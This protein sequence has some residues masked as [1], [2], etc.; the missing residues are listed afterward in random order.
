MK[1][2]SALLLTTSVMGLILGTFIGQQGAQPVHAQSQPAAPAPFAA[3]PMP[4]PLAVDPVVVS[5]TGNGAFMVTQND[6]PVPASPAPPV[7]TTLATQPATPVLTAQANTPQSAPAGEPDETALRYFAQQGDTVRLQREIERLRAL[8][9]NWQPPADPLATDFEPDQDIIAIWDMVTAGDYSGARAAIASKQEADP[10]FVPTADLLETIS[11]G[12][13]GTRLRTA[14]DSGDYQAVISLAANAPQLL[15]CASVDNLWR[16]GEAFIRTGNTQRGIDAYVY[17][18]TNCTDTA[19][20][21]ATLQKALELLDRE[22]IEPL[23]ALE[24]PAADGTGEFAA[25]K[26]DLAR[27]SIAAALEDGGEAPSEEDVTLLAAAARQSENADD[28]R[29]LG[30][31]ELDRDKPQEARRYFESAFD[32]DRS[33]QSA[34][35]LGVS[36]L[37]L[38]D[39]TAAEDALAP[40]LGESDTIDQVYGDAAAAML[41]LEPRRAVSASVLSRVVAAANESRDASIAQELGWYA[42]AYNQP[43]TAVEWFETALAWQSDLEPAAYGLM[44]AANVL[45]DSTRVEE[46]RRL[47]G[48][49]SVRIAQFGATTTSGTAIPPIPKPRPAHLAQAPVQ[50]VR[51]TTVAPQVAQVSSGG[52]ASAAGAS[53][54]G[55][56]GGGS[57][58][59]QAYRPPMSLSPAG[60]LSHAWCLMELNRPAQAADHFSRALDS[61]TQSV[62]SDAAYGQSLAFLRMGLAD[63]AAVA[64]AAAP[65]T[66]RRAVELEIAIL[67]DKATSAY[68][69]GEYAMTLNLLDARARFAPERNDLLTLRGWSYFHLKRY[70]E[71]ERIFEAV[72]ATGYGDAVAGL[73]ASRASLATY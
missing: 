14:S 61:A 41:A 19:E 4:A 10:T 3:A 58:G 26:L 60:A 59:C 66:S 17:V 69:I 72:A 40:F 5:R 64:A 52:N 37:Q 35:G 30:Y 6:V 55:G 71:A 32:A 56:G 29:L 65:L 49:R 51:A 50:A 62:R 57:S 38:E 20:R 8:Y 11:R 34:E 23:L 16:L 33:A 44:I 53:S 15:T 42:Y 46:I 39:P 21:F 70:R 63:E 48:G 67:T 43:Q 7:A 13:A 24:R 9:P 18:L 27:R 47:W 45:G 12:E 22:Q 31:F 28:L 68:S 54:G 1:R 2:T 73:E 36:L 25:L